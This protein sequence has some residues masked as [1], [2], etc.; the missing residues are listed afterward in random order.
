MKTRLCLSKTTIAYFEERNIPLPTRRYP[1][2]LILSLIN[3]RDQ[4]NLLKKQRVS[5]C[6]TSAKCK[7]KS[8][9]AWTYLLGLEITESNQETLKK[10]GI[11]NDFGLFV[12]ER[13][14]GS[15]RRARDEIRMI[16]RKVD[17]L[18][19]FEDLHIAHDFLYNL[20]LMVEPSIRRD[21]TEDKKKPIVFCTFCHRPT[22]SSYCNIH[23]KIKPSMRLI[24]KNKKDQYTTLKEIFNRALDHIQKDRSK[25]PSMH[26]HYGENAWFLEPIELNEVT[27]S[28]PKIN[29]AKIADY[30]IRWAR[31]NDFHVAFNKRVNRIMEQYKKDEWDETNI[32]CILKIIESSQKYPHMRHIIK[33]PSMRFIKSK[34]QPNNV[35]EILKEVLGYNYNETISPEDF[36]LSIKRISMMNLIAISSKKKHKLHKKILNKSYYYKEFLEQYYSV[37]AQT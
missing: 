26:F 20:F 5:I 35:V 21:N 25:I 7:G 37:S 9:S 28:K 29:T 19:S 11:P 36:A 12:K 30:L 17:D 16:L 34:W 24:D 15:L 13:C 14:E 8:P 18:T 3:I 33:P 6:Q 1:E 27:T 23:T 22:T 31:H 2:E 10:F 32:E 4:L